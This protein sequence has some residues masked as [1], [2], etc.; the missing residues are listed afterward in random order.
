MHG[1]L[2]THNESISIA[3]Y[4]SGLMGG[5]PYHPTVLYA[6]NPCYTA[7]SSIH[8]LKGRELSPRVKARRT[9]VR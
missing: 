9:H 3:D 7:V 5:R 6:Y 8:E 1:F 2:I 4:L